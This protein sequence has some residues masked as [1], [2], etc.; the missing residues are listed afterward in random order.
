MPAW[1]SWGCSGPWLTPGSGWGWGRQST[2]EDL[3]ELLGRLQDSEPLSWSIDRGPMKNPIT[4]FFYLTWKIKRHFSPHLPME[5]YTSKGASEWHSST[6]GPKPRP[7]SGC[8]SQRYSLDIPGL[9]AVVVVSHLTRG[10][11]RRRRSLPSI[12]T[13]CQ[14]PQSPP[15]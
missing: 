15:I 14:G 3:W 11:I 7:H 4:I 2:E 5:T 13:H 12:P 8:V 1:E 9:G 6:K 10:P